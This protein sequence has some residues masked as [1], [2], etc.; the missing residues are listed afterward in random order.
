MRLADLPNGMYQ[1]VDSGA[2]YSAGD[3]LD[4]LAAGATLVSGTSTP[5]PGYTPSAP[6]VVSNPSP[7]VASGTVV[8]V[9]PGLYQDTATG[10]VGPLSAFAQP[11]TTSTGDSSQLTAAFLG[12]A[13]TAIGAAGGVLAATLPKTLASNPI[14]AQL[15]PGGPPVLVRAPA[16][17]KSTDFTTILLVI[18]GAA[19]AGYVLVRLLRR[20]GGRR[21]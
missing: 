5:T 8:P 3:G 16:A 21:R 6:V 10:R 18:A 14:L 1:D 15:V 4:L 11:A 12:L 9:G 2:V 7:A 17:P 19:G 20:R 13:N